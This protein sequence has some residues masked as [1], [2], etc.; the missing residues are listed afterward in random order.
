MSNLFHSSLYRF[1]QAQPSYWE[2]SA[3]ETGLRNEI[4]QGDQQCDVAIIGGG[5]TGLSA[6]YCLARDYQ[7]DVRVLEAGHIGWG[8]SGRNGGFCC[9]GS[10]K[11]S[12]KRQ[13]AQFGI[14]ETRAYHRCLVEAV[15]MVRALGR[16]EGIDF[17]PQ[18]D[19]EY[20]VAESPKHF[21]AMTAEAEF[22]RRQLGMDFHMMSRGEFAEV[23]YDAPHQHGAMVIRPGFGLHPLRYCQGL[24][25]ATERRGAILHPHSRVVRWQKQGNRHRL[26]T[27]QGSLTAERVILTG[28]GFMPEHLH[29]GIAERPLP[30]QSQIVVTR[31]MSETELRERGWFTQ[32]PSFNSKHM[33]YYYRILSDGR[34]MLGGR[35]NHIGDPAGAERSFDDL[36]QGIARMW[37][38]FADL[39]FT[40]QWRGLVCFTRT[41]RPSVGRMPED[42]S[43]YF[44]YA[45]HGNGV[46]NASWTGR[47][48]AHWLAGP[49]SS[50]EVLPKH[51]PAIMRGR[52]PRFPLGFLR[53]QYLGLGMAWYRMLDRLDR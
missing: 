23:G 28:N 31:P 32:N 40:H 22:A 11:L 16:D 20:G 24:A 49:D 52:S 33:F 10:T 19:A 9:L 26:E 14:D 30:I 36:K 53:R 3:G 43:I 35:G 4:L 15:E 1:D 5:Y 47:A 12:L 34:F 6:A 46:A 13:L 27:E 38:R 42:P 7:L 51:L 48:L 8:A 21:A 41:L 25:Q 45:Y 37:P 29:R 39:E 2:S 17:R 18:G 44:G 50:D